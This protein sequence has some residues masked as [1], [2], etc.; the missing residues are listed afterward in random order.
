MKIVSSKEINDNNPKF[1][2]GDN[3]RISKYKNVF[4]KA[5]TLNWSEEVFVI[6]KLKNAVP[7]TYV[8]SD[9]KEEELLERFT[10]TKCKKQIKNNLELEK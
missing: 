3:V 8:I 4:A 10:K 1:K 9:F 6:K 2:N 5:Y 7:W